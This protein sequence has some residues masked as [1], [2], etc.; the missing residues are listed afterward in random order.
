VN[1]FRSHEPQNRNMALIRCPS[2]DTLHDL[3]GSFFAS[4]ARKVRCAS[5][6][7]IWE[8]VDPE[9]L[10]VTGTRSGPRVPEASEPEQDTQPLDDLES[11]A[12]AAPLGQ[13]VPAGMPAAAGISEAPAAAAPE[14]ME[15]S[16][17][18]LEAL[19]GE[20]GAITGTGTPRP[21]ATGAEVPDFDPASLARAQD[22]AAEGKEPPALRE[23]P[24]AA[25][26]RA[27]ARPPVGSK[28][29]RK[30]SG[31]TVMLMAAGMGTL[32][33][34]GLLRTEAVELVPGVAPMLESIG[35]GVKAGA[36]DIAEVHS[37]IMREEGRETLEV[38]GSITNIARAPRK[39]PVI[40]LSIR[41]ATGQEI[42]VWTATAD[43]AELAPGEKTLFRRRLASPPA[44][45]HA[46]MV[47]FV[48]KDDI[49]AS[50]R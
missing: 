4:G 11:G 7:T 17:R 15:I 46:V 14:D 19:F 20:P 22:A 38:T 34:L 48:A 13:G 8:A 25:G 27:G 44:E 3:E 43:V 2:C 37:R 10:R 42:Y 49:V 6:R 21:E 5:C 41:S 26:P 23:R 33:V 36:L 29:G 1:P 31:V 28:A 16:T 12:M 35:L 47:R 18:E 39:V 40:R 50:I 45:S 9:S 32:A 30:G 24:R